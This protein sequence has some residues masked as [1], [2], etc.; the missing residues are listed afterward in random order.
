MIIRNVLLYTFV[1]VFCPRH[2]W[3]IYK[4]VV[5]Q[6]ASVFQFTSC[7]H[8][9]FSSFQLGLH[10]THDIE[11]RRVRKHIWETTVRFYQKNPDTRR[12]SIVS[13]ERLDVIFRDRWALI[14]RDSRHKESHRVIHLSIS[15]R[16]QNASHITWTGDLNDEIIHSIENDCDYPRHIPLIYLDYEKFHCSLYRIR[17]NF[18]WKNIWWLVL[19]KRFAQTK[20]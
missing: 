1:H 16:S 3:M 11:Y 20:I 4:N 12:Y 13:Y 6:R 8:C 17:M 14:A 7:V 15:E 18:S 9:E 19:N 2:A 10:F 5:L